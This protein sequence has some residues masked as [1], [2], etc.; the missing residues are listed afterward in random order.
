[1]KKT[2]RTIF[3]A[4]SAVL[5]ATACE[6]FLDKSPDLGL[7]ES[8]IYKDF[9][10]IRGFL[11]ESYRLLNRWNMQYGGGLSRCA[12]PM[13]CTDELVSMMKNTNWIVNN[14]NQGNWYSTSRTSNWE[15]GVNG[16][17]VI[18]NSYKA[19]RIV[20]RVINNIDKVKIITGDEKKEILGQAYFYRAWY[21]YQL[22]IRYGGMPI[23]DRVFDAGE[24][25][26]PR[27][28]FDESLAWMIGDLE[29]AIDMLPVLWD[30]KNYGRPDKAAAMGVK[31]QAL[32]YGAS[33][34]FQNDM[35][36]IEKK[37]YSRERCLEA[38]KAAQEC[39]EFISENNT[40]RR[41]TK[42][43]MDDYRGIFILPTTTF[44]H[45][46][47]LWWD[48]KVMS[49]DE[50]ANTIR[51]FWQW[52][53]WDKNT[54]LDA[55]GFAAPTAD[56]VKLYE[57][58]GSDGIYYPV[59]DARSGYVG[60]DAEGKNGPW[61]DMQDRDPR[62]YNNLLLPG[63]RWGS[64]DGTPYYITSWE[65]GTAYN[66]VKTGSETASRQFSG[67]LCHKY[68][69]P[70]ASHFYV[71]AHDITGYNMYRIKS[72]YIRV[73]EMYLDYAEALFEATG[74]ATSAPSGFSM[75]PAEALNIVRARVGVTPIADEY[76][77]ASAFRETYRREREVEL[78][79]EN[80][81]LEDI[82]RWMIYDEILP[83]DTPFHNTVWTCLQG[84]NANGA[85]Y[86]DGKDLTFTYREERNTVENRVFASS[87]KYY[88]YP[89][90]GAEI[91]SLGNLVQNPGW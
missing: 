11:D 64:K 43:T 47:Y 23:I 63:Q 24:D 70:E 48:R 13:A 4:I 18:S 59:T 39:L 77:A 73:T 78:M 1:M 82:R 7:D 40:G 20:N 72:F 74:S 31:A 57:R 84:D 30:D 51:S 65:N 10:S 14:F 68:F 12:N 79:F 41:F 19:L 22:I 69:W 37:G 26:I 25:D 33:P 66:R 8:A 81:R 85:D 28:S 56:I 42:G 38:A 88:F 90:P 54:G 53:D 2:I 44:S 75:T 61:S 16:G 83:N 17:S 87:D 6:K 89:F 50:Q 91:G 55:Q 15:V 32:L 58:K 49:N 34:L 45:E 52:I 86:N 46:E 5:S 80:H 35:T 27:V 76:T 60:V 67:W 3:L 9:E 29:K 62:F 36:S 71:T 21:Y